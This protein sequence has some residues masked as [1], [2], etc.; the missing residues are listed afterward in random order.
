MA[1]FVQAYQ[2][3]LET[4]RSLVQIF[5]VVKL[6]PVSLMVAWSVT[7]LKSSNMPSVS[8]NQAAIR[9]Q[10]TVV[11]SHN[12][13]LGN[14]L[15]S[16]CIKS[17]SNISGCKTGAC[18]SDGCVVNGATFVNDTGYIG[19]MLVECFICADLIHSFTTRN[20]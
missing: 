8:G 1:A 13:I 12:R 5:L 11:L 18:F 16:T 19:I 7:S 10:P 20:I 3:P 4:G 6:V 17:G 14:Q 9:L 15:L 2:P